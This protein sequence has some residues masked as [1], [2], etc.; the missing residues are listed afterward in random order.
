MFEVDMPEWWNWQ[1]RRTQN[2]MRLKPRAGS[3]PAS[4]TIAIDTDIVTYKK[5]A[6]LALFFTSKRVFL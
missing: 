6:N 1:T 5:R 3:I 4:G 2:P